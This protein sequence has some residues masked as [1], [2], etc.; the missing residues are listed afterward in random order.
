MNSCSDQQV[1]EQEIASVEAKLRLMKTRFNAQ[2]AVARLPP[3]I[4]SQIFIDQAT[5]LREERLTMGASNDF[6]D[7]IHRSFYNWLKV[8]H[9]N[10]HWR[11]IAL[12]CVKLWTWVAFDPRLP[13]EFF[14][15]MLKRARD[16]PL[17]VVIPLFNHKSYCHGCLDADGYHENMASAMDNV[18]MLLP[19]IRELIVIINREDDDHLWESL[20]G[21]VDALEVVRIEALGFSRI[22]MHTTFTIIPAMILSS[23][24]PRL[25]SLTVSGVGI[26][27]P[28]TIFC[29]SLRHLEVLDCK[30]DGEDDDLGP[31]LS[32]LRATPFLET[33]KL[34][35]PRGHTMESLSARHDFTALTHLKQLHITASI[36]RLS[37]FLVHVQVPA[38]ASL[39]FKLI[40]T[41]I[42]P[43]KEDFLE[44][45]K[46]LFED[47]TIYQAACTLGEPI[48]AWANTAPATTTCRIW[49]A[50]G[51]TIPQYVQHDRWTHQLEHL[52]GLTPRLTLESMSSV[53][54]EPIATILQ[55]LELT[56]MRM[57]HIS[58]STTGKAWASI[59]Q[60]ASAL[61][62]LRMTGMCTFAI[63]SLLAEGRQALEPVDVALRIKAGM[64]EWHWARFGRDEERAEGGEV[65]AQWELRDVISKMMVDEDAGNV[66]P[67]TSDRTADTLFPHLRVLQ[68]VDV[69][70][71]LPD[72]TKARGLQGY[73]H[74][75][76]VDIMRF[77][78]TRA[79]YGF[80]VATL[81]KSLMLRRAEGAADLIRVDFEGCHC[82]STTQLASLAG[83]TAEVWWDGTVVD[84]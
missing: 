54:L 10:R 81:A 75:A 13:D 31:I 46:Y 27:T 64:D 44:A 38:G 62:S 50:E 61:T 19:R 2:S 20:D 51:N 12:G 57:L 17:M 29:S 21:P 84:T 1:L 73:Q 53:S 3:E 79:K 82:E 72:G 40:D 26:D 43:Y 24:T 65:G 9:V 6:P 36:Q 78:A 39:H 37:G 33:L 48:Q 35:W 18:H 83:I 28:N 58:G 22:A 15:T 80:D 8:S 42:P 4:L 30:F 45:I 77:R 41:M 5:M 68:I 34:A 32:A 59:F 16:L 67:S 71:S 76:A 11:E 23:H 47:Q 49:A 56:K 52:H 55:S 74:A 14:Q 69:D 7:H 60:S 70:L 63:P 66:K 25:H